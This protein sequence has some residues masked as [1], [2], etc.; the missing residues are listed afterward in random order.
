MEDQ[1]VHPEASDPIF[2][3]SEG[4]TWREPSHGEHYRT[5]SFCGSIHPDDLAAE[6]EW[7]AD[8]ASPKYGWPHKFYV[9]VANRD[10]SRLFR[11]GTSNSR[12]KPYKSRDA[13]DWVSVE[14]L[15]PEQREAAERDGGP[16]LSN[17]TY[18]L[19]GERATHWAKFYSIHLKDVAISRET[20]ERIAEVSGL[21]FH[22]HGTKVSWERV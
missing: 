22:F 5:C 8:W 7:H 12:T 13:A 2:K 18:Y 14:D 3:L 15:T 10:P 1:S 17:V 9:Q 20:R 19:F 6:T 4:W 16:G 21:R 11:I